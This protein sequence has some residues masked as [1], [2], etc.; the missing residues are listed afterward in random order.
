M[1][2]K[3]IIPIVLV[4]AILGAGIYLLSL[5]S[6]T[7]PT[8]G[9][10][11][12]D[13]RPACDSIK[14]PDYCALMNEIDAYGNQA[15]NIGSYA[16]LISRIDEKKSHTLINDEQAISL[17]N[18]SLTTC[19]RMIQ[20][21]VNKQCRS[22]SPADVGQRR[23]LRDAL[24]NLERVSQASLDTKSQE[25]KSRMITTLKQIEEAF[26]INDKVVS[27]L[28]REKYNADKT[29]NFRNRIQTYL[30]D[31]DFKQNANITSELNQAKSNLS[32]FEDWRTENT[33]QRIDNFLYLNPAQNAVNDF[34]TIQKARG[35]QPAI[36]NRAYP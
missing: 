27:Y 21:E 28:Q 32:A 16:I 13:D 29:A 22:A 26:E 12:T 36:I 14:T 24:N 7:V 18:W 17:R 19:L 31:G 10:G 20:E 9:D 3:R 15:F 1:N 4:L 23:A 34:F 30:S 8:G 2:T 33:D 35:N 6:A 11:Q 5:D 25:S